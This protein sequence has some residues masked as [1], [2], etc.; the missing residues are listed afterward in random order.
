MTNVAECN[1]M[2]TPGR[3]VGAVAD[4]V[5][6]KERLAELEETLAEQFAEA[7]ELS[8]LIR[9]KLEGIATDG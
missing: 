5:P 3:H 6:F 7:E 2:L 4:E 9:T 8:A 1:H